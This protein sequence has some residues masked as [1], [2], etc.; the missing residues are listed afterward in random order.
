MTALKKYERLECIGLWR[1]NPAAQRACAGCTEC[2]ATTRQRPRRERRELDVL[3]EQGLR[4]L[5]L[6]PRPSTMAR[7]AGALIRA[8]FIR[9][10]TRAA[11]AAHR[12]VCES[13]KCMPTDECATKMACV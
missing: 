11:S 9:E 4:A 6:A 5:G 8:F 10:P 13:N 1:S 2:E 3:P 7:T 12:L